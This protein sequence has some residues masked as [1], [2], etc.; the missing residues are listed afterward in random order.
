MPLPLLAF[1]AAGAT[2]AKG[3]AN[4]QVSGNT[5]NAPVVKECRHRENAGLFKRGLR[6]TLNPGVFVSIRELS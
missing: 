4:A 1:V 3:G 6:I 2:A 5:S